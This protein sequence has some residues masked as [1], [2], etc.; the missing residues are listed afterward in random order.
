MKNNLCELTLVEAK[1]KLEN[2]EISSFELVESFFKQIKKVD[3]KIKSYLTLDE[4]ALEKAKECDQRRKRGEEK[5]LLGIPYAVKD[6]LSTKNLRTTASDKILENHHP[7]YDATVVDRINKEGA[8]VLGK[9]NC[10]PFAFGCSTENSAFGPTRNPWDL[11]RVPG[12]SSGGSAAAVAA[13]EC[14]FALGTDTGGSIRQPAAFCNIVGLKPTYGVFSRYGLLAMASSFDCPGPMTKTVEDA[15]LIFNVIQGKDSLDATSSEET[16]TRKTK[17]RIGLPKEYYSFG[18]DLEIKK[19]VIQAAKTLEKNGFSLE[20][21]SLPYTKYGIAVYY[22]LVPSEIS[23]NMARYDGI[24]YGQERKSFSDEVKRRIM[25]GTYALS[26]GYYDAFYLK[27]SKVRAII[28][29]DFKNAFKKVDLLLSP[30]SPTPP[31][32]I[33]EKF[34]DPLQ[35]YLEDILTVN[36]N[37][38]GIPSLAIP[39]GFTKAGLPIGMQIA[40]PRFAEESIFL[41]GKTYQELTSWHKE[42]PKL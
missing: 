35:M 39:C 24:R 1:N 9:T 36:M 3:T 15:K 38:A 7:L 13:D 11:K 34:S 12:G 30:V 33:G 16:L 25:L 26:A 19:S 5:K 17:L 42:K 4:S 41:V 20:E 21:V 28:S 18:I 31:F 32:E 10:D 23:S 22:I 37:L 29:Q 8:I 14:V 27:A 2:K 6:V 40:G